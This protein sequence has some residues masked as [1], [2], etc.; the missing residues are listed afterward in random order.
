MKTMRPIRETIPVEEAKALLN[1]AATGEGA[2][3]G[4]M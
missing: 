1:K 4:F 2:A 3:N